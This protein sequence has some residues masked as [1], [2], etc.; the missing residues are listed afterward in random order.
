MNI[1]PNVLLFSAILILLAG[2]ASLTGIDPSLLTASTSKSYVEIKSPFAWEERF[3]I[4]GSTQRLTLAA[5][6][7][8]AKY[9]EGTA[10]TYYEGKGKCLKSEVT[11]DDKTRKDF[12][13]TMLCG[14]FVPNSAENRVI[15]YYYI[16]PEANRK[17]I[18]ESGQ[19]GT[20]IHAFAEAEADNLKYLLYQPDATAL[21][22]AITVV[23]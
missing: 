23:K 16:D 19:T 12:S 21:K 15:V 20:L 7:Y 13:T 3:N 10:G 9:D 18:A 2:C 17:A 22:A 11:Y 4:D 5:G 1:Q 14:V 8:T 6:K